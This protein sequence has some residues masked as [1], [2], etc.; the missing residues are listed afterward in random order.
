MSVA[1]PLISVVIPTY[2]RGFCIARAIDTVL[3][4]TRTANEVI[5]VDDGSGDD[6]RE[7]VR[8]YGDRVTYLF[9]RNA[10]VSA[11]RNA[12][13][14]A[15]R[16]EWIAFLDSDDEWIPE[17]LE[18][19]CSDVTKHPRAIAHMTDCS[20]GEGDEDRLSIFGMRGLRSEFE[21]SPMRERPLCDVLQSAFFPSSWLVRRDAIDASGYFDPT[22]RVCE[23]TDLLSRI[24]LLGPFAVNCTAG[25]KLQRQGGDSGLSDL[26]RVSRLEYLENVRRTFGHLS[27]SQ[28]LT[29]PERDHVRKEYSAAYVEIA[30]LHGMNGNTSGF[31]DAL[32][33]SLAANPT[34]YSLLKAATLK[35][36]GVRAYE[37]LRK[38]KDAGR[39]SAPRRS[40]AN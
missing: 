11:A 28:Q 34:V 1:D 6:T 39:V 38:R 29:R 31:C 10:G 4:Q 30:V 3:C 7:I 23:D 13:V 40:A 32:K 33:S 21:R 36:L 22:M 15:A 20:L 19:Q 14:R 18:L 35:S 24:A 8:S 26:Y 25:T 5:V 27:R 2:N 17:K 16:G 37:V 9:Q 12:G